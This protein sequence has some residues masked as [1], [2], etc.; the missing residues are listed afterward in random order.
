V[1]W[2]PKLPGFEVFVDGKGGS[3]MTSLYFTLTKIMSCLHTIAQSGEEVS[4]FSETVSKI[5]KVVQ[6]MEDT[7]DVEV[8]FLLLKELQNSMDDLEKCLT[9]LS[10]K[11]KLARFVSSNR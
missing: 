3:N 1:T 2:L 9:Q 8:P 4:D 6:R 5:Q 10:G 7:M 11:G